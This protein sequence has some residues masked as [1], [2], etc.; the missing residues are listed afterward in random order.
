MN[1]RM[2][3]FICILLS[4]TFIFFITIFFYTN[5]SAKQFRRRMGVD[6]EFRWIWLIK[7]TFSLVFFEI[8]HVTFL[9]KKIIINDKFHSPAE[10]NNAKL[11]KILVLKK[12][13][14]RIDSV[15][16]PSY[17]A[18]GSLVNIIVSLKTCQRFSMFLALIP[19][20]ATV[21]DQKDRQNSIFKIGDKTSMLCKAMTPYMV[22][23]I[24]R[25]VTW[26]LL[27]PFFLFL[28]NISIANI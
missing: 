19:R 17:I 7:Y 1:K 5:W 18:I 26:I 20:T 16:L 13:L 14:P 24:K 6:H 25:M 15:L 9:S 2:L 27:K 28:A 3:F 4:Q 12:L 21:S 22:H 10:L 11:E 8:Y 23:K